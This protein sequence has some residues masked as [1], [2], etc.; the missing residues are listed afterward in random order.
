MRRSVSARMGLSLG[1]RSGSSAAAGGGKARPEGAPASGGT[2]PPL[3]RRLGA[4]LAGRCRVARAQMRI[5]AKVMEGSG[6]AG[7][8]VG[9]AGEHEEGDGGGGERAG[10]AGEAEER[11]SRARC[12][13]R[14]SPW[15]GAGWRRA[16]ARRAAAGRGGG[17]RGASAS[18]RTEERAKQAAARMRKGVVGRTGRTTPTRP[19]AVKRRPAARKSARRT[20]ARCAGAGGLSRARRSRAC[21]G[22]GSHGSAL[23]L[24]ADHHPLDGRRVA[25]A[26]VERHVGAHLPA[27]VDRVRRRRRP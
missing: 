26:L 27:G 15:R 14:P 13:R 7:E 1:W 21:R 22:S 19:M 11:R 9:E 25:H 23:D 18:S 5:C 24:A 20:R 8:D 12:R 17:G 3:G 2:R 4:L 6:R 10:V 16:R